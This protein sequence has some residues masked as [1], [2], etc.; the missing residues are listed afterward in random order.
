MRVI[1]NREMKNNSWLIALLL[2]IPK[3]V[4]SFG[5]YQQQQQQQ[6]RCE[7]VGVLSST[8]LF[9]QLLGMNCAT[10]TDFK[11]S[12]EGFCKRGGETDIHSD[13]WGLAFYQKD[14]GG[15]GD[16]TDTDDSGGVVRQFHDVEAASTSPL[17]RDLCSTKSSIRTN[18]MMGHIRYAT[19][20]HVNLANVHPFCR[21]MW[22]IEWCF[23]HN[24]EVPLF[25]SHPYDDDPQQ[26]NNEKE[27]E[28]ENE[29]TITN[30][31]ITPT[32]RRLTALSVGT[33]VTGDGT[34]EDYYF[35]P[36][37]TTDSEATFCAI[38]NALRAKFQTLPSYPI[39]YEALQQLC[40]EITQHDPEGTILNFLLT[41]GPH[42]QWVYSW[43]GSRPGSKVWNGLHYT[44][45]EFP[46]TKCHLCDLDYTV[47][48]STHTTDQDCVSVIATKPLT[49]DEDWVELQRGELILFDQ[50]KPH[51]TPYDLFKV[52]LSGHGLHSAAMERPI[53]EE[54]MRIYNLNPQHFMGECI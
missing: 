5:V 7:T 43:P 4:S 29:S 34:T 19:V 6:R 26:P 10:P 18:N 25:S 47:D 46:F 35:Q 51:M 1:K 39:L 53:L 13:G 12:L 15:D 16:D 21:E 42:T 8:A 37:G 30:T 22:G 40:N 44:V 17:A 23:C 27:N 38:L 45:R 28:N 9:C 31:N 3:S 36:V 14:G 24:G 48:F 54:D 50:G 33:S 41:C 32:Q 49:D 52:E 2:A 11:F 20:G